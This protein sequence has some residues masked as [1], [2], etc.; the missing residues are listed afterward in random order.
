MGKS[1]TYRAKKRFGQNFLCNDAIIHAIIKS[2]GASSVDSVLEIGPGLGVL[3]S[4]LQPTVK[5]LDIIEIDRDL[6]QHLHKTLG[7]HANLHLHEQ[8]VLKVDF[9]SFFAD[10]TQKL[11]VVGNLPYNIATEIIF[12]LVKF[13]DNIHAMYFLVQQEVAKRLCATPG[14]KAYGRLSIMVGL[15]CEVDIILNVPPEAFSPAPKIQS[16][17]IRLRPHDKPKYHID[18]LELFSKLI[19]QAFNQR[20]KKISN[21]LKGLVDEKILNMA[22]I[23]INFRAEDI[24]IEQYVR[25]SNLVSLSL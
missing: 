11:K 5:S 23:D 25:L 20:R 18:N 6:C 19:K 1:G 3:T 17:F 10:F 2:I 21:A 7:H 4:I 14:N 9:A 22:N 15:Y 8:D 24:S 16:S 13:A 12:R